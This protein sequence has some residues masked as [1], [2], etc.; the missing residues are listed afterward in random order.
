[1]RHEKHYLQV[2]ITTKQNIRASVATINIITATTRR[3]IPAPFVKTRL[4]NSNM[5]ILVRE[6]ASANAHSTGTDQSQAF[7]KH[8]N[9]GAY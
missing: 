5:D 4:V 3:M 1:M 7:D 8:I 2:K 6:T 9:S